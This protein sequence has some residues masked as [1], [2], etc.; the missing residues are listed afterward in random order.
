M[1]TLLQERGY[2]VVMYYNDHTPAHVHVK[3]AGNEALVQLDPIVIMDNYGYNRGELNTIIEIIAD[4]Q[5]MLIDAWNSYYGE[6][7][8]E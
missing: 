8:D 3:K 1:P 2:R 6:G 7:E 4:N 5:Q